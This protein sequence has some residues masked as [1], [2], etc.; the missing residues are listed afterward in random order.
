MKLQRIVYPSVFVS[1]FLIFFTLY[2]LFIGRNYVNMYG[3][4]MIKITKGDNLRSVASKLEQGQVIY[5]GA[6]DD[7]S[8]SDA[9]DL[10]GARNYVSEALQEAMTTG[11][12]EP[13]L[14]RFLRQP[15]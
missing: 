3:E 11:E 1:S 13:V 2:L 12:I 10:N 6:I 14:R 4:T 5:N 8:T 7:K 9:S 15:A